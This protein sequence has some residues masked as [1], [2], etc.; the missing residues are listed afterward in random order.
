MLLQC[1]TD[2]CSP[3]LTASVCVC[4]MVEDRFRSGTE[5]QQQVNVLHSRFYLSC[6]Q[7]ELKVEIL[8]PLTVKVELVLA[9]LYVVESFNPQEYMIMFVDEL[10]IY[11]YLKPLAG[12]YDCYVACCK[13][14]NSTPDSYLSRSS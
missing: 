14:Y 13:K 4:A 10:V 1:V 6:H 12:N 9:I 7:S 3:P 5:H 2:A 8:M 11:F